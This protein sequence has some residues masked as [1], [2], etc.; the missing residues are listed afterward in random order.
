VAAL[1]CFGLALFVLDKILR[2]F[3]L[4][5]ST[6]LWAI[7][8][9]ALNPNSIFHGIGYPESFFSLLV[10]VA[11]LK[12]LLWIRE[13]KIPDLLGALLMIFLM[14]LTRPIVLQFGLSAV[15]TMAL[16]P[17]ILRDT[18]NS[19]NTTNSAKRQRLFVFLTLGVIACVLG[20]LPFGFHCL[21]KFGNFWQ[22][23]DAQKYW[24][25]TPG[26]HWTLFTNP[27]SVGGSDN[28][29]VW[30]LH[31]FYLPAILVA[32]FLVRA[33]NSRGKESG[34]SDIPAW[35]LGLFCALIAAAHSGIA[36]V[37]YPIFMSLGRHVLATPFFF[38]AAAILIDPFLTN[39]KRAR[40][41]FGW[42]AIAALYLIHFWTRFARVAWIG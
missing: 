1:I 38:I 41:A 29:L 4:S 39:P 23:F 15:L 6:R 3:T 13:G 22:P 28:V 5:S 2:T 16:T 12:A 40:V 32:G 26:L 24:D 14:G 19:A 36:F 25:R 21:G 10:T 8:A 7:S 18:T 20:Y 42:V 11:I 17:L 30:D 31:A 37:T 9:F 35:S 27:R 33:L 34:R